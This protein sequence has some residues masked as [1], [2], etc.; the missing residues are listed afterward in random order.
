[1]I[2][3]RLHGHRQAV[4][5]LR[6]SGRRDV[7][8]VSRETPRPPPFPRPP[9]P[10]ALGKPSGLRNLATLVKPRGFTW[11]YRGNLAR[12]GGNGAGPTPA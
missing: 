3:Q 8:G 11:N 9:R 10:S 6:V 2:N 12:Q 7:A 4:Q 5:P 1:M